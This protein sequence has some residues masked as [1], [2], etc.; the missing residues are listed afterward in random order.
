MEKFKQ[1]DWKG[2]YKSVARNIYQK[3]NIYRVRVMVNGFRHD[4]HFIDYKRA[5]KLRDTLLYL[6]K[7]SKV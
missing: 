7:G 4:A 5:V 6:Q 1:F 3:G 2:P